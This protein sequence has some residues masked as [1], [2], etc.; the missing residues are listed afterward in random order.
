M[1]LHWST[2]VQAIAPH[3]SEMSHHI[4]PLL[5]LFLL[6][7][8]LFLLLLSSSS[9]PF[10]EFLTLFLLLFLLLH[11][12]NYS[13]PLSPTP[14]GKLIHAQSLTKMADKTHKIKEVLGRFE[15]MR[16][17]ACRAQYLKDQNPG[18]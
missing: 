11:Q 6:L 16:I 1:A 14:R 7:F 13:D 8:L 9:H 15:D 5:L 12:V 10:P 17:Q 18:I 3:S 2:L 4:T